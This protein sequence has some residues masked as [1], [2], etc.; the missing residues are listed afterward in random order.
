MIA[1]YRKA[2]DVVG[3]TFD[4]DAYCRDCSELLP[5]ATAAGDAPAPVFASDNVHGL[6]CRICGE[7]LQ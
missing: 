4:G 5:A 2:W 6:A 3:H 7:V 1:Y